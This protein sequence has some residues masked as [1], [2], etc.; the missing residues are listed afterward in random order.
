MK[1]NRVL[2]LKNKLENEAVKKHFE[3]ILKENA[4]TFMASI[5]EMVSSDKK[6]QE[7]NL[8]DI[9]R[10]GYK[11][12]ELKLPLSK[13]LGFVFIIARKDHKVLKPSI[14]IGY[15]GYIQLILRTNLYVNINVSVVYEGMEVVRDII[16]GDVRISDTATSEN[17][18]GYIAYI[19]MKS[20]FKKCL[21]WKKEE[22]EA[23]A[24]KYVQ[25]YSSAYSPWQTGFDGMAQKTVLTNLL[26]KYGMISINMVTLYAEDRNLP[27]N[28]V[29]IE[30]G[31]NEVE[32]SEQEVL[33]NEPEVEQEQEPETETEPSPEF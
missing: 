26:K 28:I 17:A 14:Q 12:A 32:Y 3:Q 18:I 23:H 8:N 22:V 20:G 10:E 11:A 4:G 15:K 25:N 9:I 16:T 2:E 27:Q 31:K 33:E 13:L 29:P 7:C 24:S 30:V 6:L 5:V 1:E 19:E 21:Y